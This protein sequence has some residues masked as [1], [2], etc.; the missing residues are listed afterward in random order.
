MIILYS[1]PLCP[2][3]DGAEH[4]LKKNGF[5]YTKI[6]VSED[7]D[8][9]NFIKSKGHRTVPQ[10]Y[11]EDK[12]LVEGGYDSLRKLLPSELNDR[13]QQHVNGQEI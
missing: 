6:D 12:L 9:L 5:E 1:K 4:Y 13:I 3:C 7:L 11:L 10:I 2:Y 8:S